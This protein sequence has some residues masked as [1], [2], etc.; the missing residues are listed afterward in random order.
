[1]PTI[2]AANRSS[3]LIGGKALDGLQE[4]T[5]QTVRPRSDIPAIGTDERIGV[6]F[7]TTSVTGTLR[8]RSASKDL[9]DLLAGKGAFQIMASLKPS[10]SDEATTVTMDECFLEGKGFGMVAGG[11]AEVVYQFS[12]TRVTVAGAS[13]K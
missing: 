6:I 5:F 1:M 13:G 10:G 7:G 3:V 11:V 4:I 2:L 8:V 9:D 12:A